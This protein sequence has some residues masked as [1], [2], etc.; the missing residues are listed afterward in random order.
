MA[1]QDLR[2]D[3]SPSEP[4]MAPGNPEARSAKP[5]NEADDFELLRWF[6]ETFS[7][8]LLL[9]WSAA[10]A[11]TKKLLTTP[12]LSERQLSA[13]IAAAWKDTIE[14]LANSQDIIEHFQYRVMELR[15]NG[16]LSGDPREAKKLNVVPEEL[17]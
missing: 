8:D 11:E 7:S 3:P 16:I 17:R 12:G 13:G 10:S 9:A 15:I 2:S 14:K 1:P 4:F 5:M 6:H